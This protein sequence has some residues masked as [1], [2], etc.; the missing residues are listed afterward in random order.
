MRNVSIA[1]DDDDDDDDDDE[2]FYSL[3]TRFYKV[4]YI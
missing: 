1:Y 3:R 2:H 4:I